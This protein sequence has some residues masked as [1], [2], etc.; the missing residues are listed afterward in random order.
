VDACGSIWEKDKAK[1][2]SGQY[3]ELAGKEISDEAQ[4]KFV[5]EDTNP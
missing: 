5:T 4:L 1:Y 3:A 2:Y